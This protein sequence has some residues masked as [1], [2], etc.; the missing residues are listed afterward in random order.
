MGNS[1]PT[2]DCRVPSKEELW[3]M[4]ERC[5]KEQPLLY[6]Y[7]CELQTIADPTGMV[8]EI[9]SLTQQR[10]ALVG[11]RER[12]NW[13][14]KQHL[15]VGKRGRDKIWRI[16]EFWM[17]APRGVEHEVT[18]LP[19]VGGFWTHHDLASAIDSAMRQDL[20]SET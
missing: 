2:P 18:K 20:E 19:P 4:L 5:A 13:L 15:T 16:G 1:I 3:P 6:R 9:A 7:I 8:Q 11:D 14:E 17:V 10:N 12:L